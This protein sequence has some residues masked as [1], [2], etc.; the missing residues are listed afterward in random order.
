MYYK[1]MSV[2]SGPPEESN[3]RKC[4]AVKL[5]ADWP[6]TRAPAPLLRLPENLIRWAHGSSI[7][8]VRRLR[9]QRGRLRRVKGRLSP[10]RGAPAAVSSA[11]LARPRNAGVRIQ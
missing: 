9:L 10:R 5:A 3:A 1:E 4:G 2:W 11:R 8:D 6:A 7:T